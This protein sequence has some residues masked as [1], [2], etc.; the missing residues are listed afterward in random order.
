MP[1]LLSNVCSQQVCSMPIKKCTLCS[2][3]YLWACLVSSAV[4]ACCRH[5]PPQRL[6]QQAGVRESA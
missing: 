2:A 5:A 1:G 4:L 6:S 3:Q